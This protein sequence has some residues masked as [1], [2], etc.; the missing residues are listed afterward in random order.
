MNTRTQLD[1]EATERLESI[2]TI[3]ASVS[4]FKID[5]SRGFPS[6]RVGQPRDDRSHGIPGRIPEEVERKLGLSHH[7][8]YVEVFVERTEL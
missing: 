1:E 3:I 4:L 2:G 7:G 5:N 8:T 6:R